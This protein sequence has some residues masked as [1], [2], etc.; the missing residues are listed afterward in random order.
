MPTTKPRHYAR[1]ETNIWG[2]APSSKERLDYCLW[3]DAYLQARMPQVTGDVLAE[4][5][6][7]LIA[8]RSN[9]IGFASKG[10]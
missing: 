1:A 9:A 10:S 7:G 5:S 4:L 3:W 2:A 8:M 6:K